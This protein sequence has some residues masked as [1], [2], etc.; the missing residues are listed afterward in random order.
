MPASATRALIAWFRSVSGRTQAKAT[1][2]STTITVSLQA[3]HDAALPS[4]EGAQWVAQIERIQPCLKVRYR[5]ARPPLIHKHQRVAVF[6]VARGSDRAAG[7]EEAFIRVLLPAGLCL[8]RAHGARLALVGE[9][10]SRSRL[11][12]CSRT[13]R[14]VVGERQGQLQVGSTHSTH[15]PARNATAAYPRQS[16]SRGD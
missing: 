1:P 9:R 13:G 10:P 14:D 2:A 11:K 7:R 16:R 5:S 4:F 3:L 15:A 8:E 6:D 12:P